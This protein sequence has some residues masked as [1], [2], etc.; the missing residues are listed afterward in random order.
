ML[1]LGSGGQGLRR[2][3][4]KCLVYAHYFVT[5][6]QRPEINI[7]EWQRFFILELRKGGDMCFFII[8]FLLFLYEIHSDFTKRNRCTMKGAG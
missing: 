5:L 8:L 3:Q 2:T 6:Q 7:A 4:N 1:S